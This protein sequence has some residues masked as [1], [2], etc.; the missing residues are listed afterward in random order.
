MSETRQLLERARLR[1]PRADYELEDL[2]EHRARTQRSERVR[3]GALALTITVVVG[4]LAFS[5]L[6]ER[7]P[8]NIAATGGHGLPPATTALPVA[9]ECWTTARWP[10]SPTTACP[11]RW[12]G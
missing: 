10:G 6:R 12:G 1:A 2:R 8:A 5:I 9:S 11:R 4:T 3:A 7:E